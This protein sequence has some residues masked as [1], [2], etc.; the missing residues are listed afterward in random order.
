MSTADDIALSPHRRLPRP[1]VERFIK[2]VPLLT[3]ILNALRHITMMIRKQAG[4]FNSTGS[5]KILKRQSGPMS[6]TERGKAIKKMMPHEFVVSDTVKKAIFHPVI[7]IQPF[8]GQAQLTTPAH[9]DTNAEIA[10]NHPADNV[11]IINFKRTF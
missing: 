10:M 4:K 3:E 6:K 11:V 2:A 8:L 1:A 9:I 5:A 7:G